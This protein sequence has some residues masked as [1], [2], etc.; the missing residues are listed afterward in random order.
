MLHGR[1]DRKIEKD[2]RERDR[3]DPMRLPRIQQ[4]NNEKPSTGRPGERRAP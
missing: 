1:H 3:V 2:G 4:S